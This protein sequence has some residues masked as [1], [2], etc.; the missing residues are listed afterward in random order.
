MTYPLPLDP[1]PSSIEAVMSQLP[2]DARARLAWFPTEFRAR[3]VEPLREA[4][5]ER[6]PAVADELVLPAYRL[7]LRLGRAT[8]ILLQDPAFAELLNPSDPDELE[9]GSVQRRIDARLRAHRPRAAGDLREALA[10]LRAV[11]SALVADYRTELSL[12]ASAFDPSEPESMDDDLGDDLSLPVSFVFRGLLLT[13][14][15]SELVLSDAAIPP[16]FELW[17]RMASREVQAAANALRA[18]GLGVPTAVGASRT[19]VGRREGL[20]LVRT[21][22]LPPGV[23]EM[24]RTE[25]HPEE[26]W[27]FGSRARG[28]HGPDSDWDLLVVVPDDVDPDALVE[29]PRLVRLRRARVEVFLVRRE[30]FQKARSIVGTLSHIAATQ[31]R[32]IHGA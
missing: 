5:A 26:I 12:A 8:A 25:L 18:A 31:G 27:L 3:F 28:T 11:V 1:T 7:F 15:A 6:L 20:S 9:T 16:T 23:L 17:C 13:V 10:W 21:D 14:A 29:R 30:E 2:A 32:R 19:A 22:P 24:L 4:T